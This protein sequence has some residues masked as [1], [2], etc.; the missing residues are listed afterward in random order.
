MDPGA[1]R[2]FERLFAS[3][4]AIRSTRTPR[5]SPEEPNPS[6]SNP[7]PD[8]PPWWS[9]DDMD[10]RASQASQ[11]A[12]APQAA[13]GSAGRKPCRKPR[14]PARTRLRA[15]DSGRTTSGSRGR[16]SRTKS[17][18]ASRTAI[19]GRRRLARRLREAG[20]EKSLRAELT[21]AAMPPDGRL[22][23]CGVMVINPP[24]KLAAELATIG[25]VLARLLGRDAGRGFTLD[26]R[27]A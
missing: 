3:Y 15:K 16:P 8:L 10:A 23:A 24:W 6:P 13:A 20:V 22:Q 19:G 5:P 12:Q 7:G 17:A 27:E 4:D 18:N 26:S 2:N 14:R 11:A 25:P 9:P 1:P 21:V